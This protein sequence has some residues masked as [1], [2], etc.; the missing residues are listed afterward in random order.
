VRR[1]AVSVAAALSL[2]CAA[3]PARAPA[4][5]PA[6]A[7]AYTPNAGEQ[8]FLD[9]LSRRTFDWF[10]ETTN[11]RNGLTPD[12][13]PTKSFSSV[14]AVG[15][16]LTAYAIGVERG[17]VARDSARERT[18]TTLRFF[19]RAP[20]GDSATGVTGYRGFFYHFLDMETGLRFRNVELSTIDTAL[21]LGGVLVAREYFDGADP[22]EAEVRALADSIYLRVDWKWAE[23][24]RPLVSMGWH[25][26]RPTQNHDADGFI[27]TNWFGYT[28]GMLLYALAF[29]SPT[30]PID[31]S[32]WNAW[33][34]TYKWDTFQ[35]QTF[36]QFAPLFGHQYSQL[37][38]DYR[39]I[40]DAYMRGKGMDYFENSRR[41]ALSQRAYAIANP[42]GWRDYSA[43][44]W[45]LTAS[46]GPLDSTFTLD[47]RTRRFHTYWARGAGADEIN[48]DGTIAPTAVGGSVPF[49]PEVT[50]PS[51]LAMRRRYGDDLFARYGFLDAF[52]PTL[53][54]PGPRFT[55]GRQ[56]PGKLWVDVDY[57]GID[58]GP[59]LAQ[60]ENYRSGLVWRLLR[61]NP[62]VA[63][64]LCRAGFSGGWLEGRC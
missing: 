17:W 42:N 62:Y 1:L 51:L 15:F 18:L 58:Q 38:I 12:R 36:V 44:V 30:H 2:G 14:A 53:R 59:I 5:A 25:P 4:P 20:Q 54:D 29:G 63:R 55:Q 13:W 8:A 26:E 9:T 11:P 48:D 27:R 41:A 10:W 50:I 31:A 22:H 45:G 6:P 64:G 43:D 23:N 28:E 40:R 24:G 61:K 32:A 57:L 35:G 19:W 16:G 60:L 39:G 3:A 49:A 7:P 52:N 47:G 33:T 21:L 37:F 56:V 46:D 34:A